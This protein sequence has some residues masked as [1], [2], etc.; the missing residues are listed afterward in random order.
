[1]PEALQVLDRFPDAVALADGGWRL[2]YLNAAAA[3]LS[4]TAEN[5]LAGKSLWD[6]LPQTLPGETRELLDRAMLDRVETDFEYEYARRWYHVR[7]QPADG[8][9]LLFI[10]DV[11]GA[12]CY[13]RLFET[14]AE[15]ILI[16]NDEGRYVDVNRS[17]C[18]I[19]KTTRERLIGAHF[20]EFIPPEMLDQAVAAFEEL[21]RGGATPVDFP[22]RAAD[23]VP[24]SC[25][26]QRPAIIFRACI[27]AAAATSAS[28]NAR[29]GNA[30]CCSSAR[31][32]PWSI[33]NGCRAN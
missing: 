31:R 2:R 29:N 15:G 17:Y 7:V 25:R 23:G 5:D 24:S 14:T 19:L 27:S 26:G 12:K 18:R 3:T 21:R 9:L 20:R 32:K 1:M 28:K 4:S 6:V 33:R 13:R 11:T 8:G 16:V 30:L 10:R 22:L